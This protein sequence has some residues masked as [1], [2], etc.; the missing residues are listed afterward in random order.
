MRFFVITLFRFMTEISHFQ[1]AIQDHLDQQS[2]GQ[3][4][5]ELYDPIRYILSLGGKRF[6]PVITLLTASMFTDDWQKAV[7]PSVAVEVFHNF[8]LMHDDFMDAA[9]IRRGQPT[10]H[11][12]W[13]TN[14]A[15][16][17]GDVMLVKAFEILA[18]TQTDDLKK[19]LKRFSITS[20]EVCEGQQLDMNYESV[21]VVSKEEYIEMIRLKTSVLVGF[22]MELGGIMAGANETTTR[23][24]YDA[25]VNIGLGFQL[26]DDLL[27]VYG[28]ANVF[29]KQIGGDIIANKKTYLL[30]DAI[31]NARN[32][33]AEI[34][35]GWLSEVN[36]DKD[37]KIKEITE[38][39]NRLGVKERTEKV[40]EHYFNKGFEI[41]EKIQAPLVK[42]KVLIDFIEQLAARR[43]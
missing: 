16:L 21:P 38:V 41:L 43:K 17:S 37:R 25:G 39:Y 11:K 31:E 19:L 4:P 9:P 10:V 6:R 36:F 5:A 33:D 3:Y 23:D 32:K 27:D 13:N 1:K 18:D 2:F 12:K 8:T 26:M 34:L 22:S 40:I 20:A 42:K 30:I 35:Q 14:I 7:T 28:D 29:G 15:I 24:L